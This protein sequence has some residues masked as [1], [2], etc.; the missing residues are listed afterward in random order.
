MEGGIVFGAVATLAGG[1]ALL[2]YPIALPLSTH[3]LIQE[4]RDNNIDLFISESS[5]YF[6]DVIL[7]SGV[8]SLWS[9]SPEMW[10]LIPVGLIVHE[11]QGVRML[12]ALN[13]A[14]SVSCR[15]VKQ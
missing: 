9:Y 15:S 14:R 7:A 4:I 10:V 13:R 1:G 12:R 11:V 3:F 8:G 5:L 2:F 6:A